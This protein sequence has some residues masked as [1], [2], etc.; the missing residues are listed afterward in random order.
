MCNRVHRDIRPHAESAPLNSQSSP[1]ERNDYTINTELHTMEDSMT[2]RGHDAISAA[3]ELHLPLGKYSEE[4]HRG[5]RLDLSLKEAHKLAAI[6]E[7]LIFLDLDID[8]LDIQALAALSIALGGKPGQSFLQL[9]DEFDLEGDDDR[10]DIFEAMARRW[11][12]L[13]LKLH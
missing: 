1:L 5:F 2:I 6:D 11:S 10:A 9:R 12:A 4:S 8:R 13:K 7:N 3:K